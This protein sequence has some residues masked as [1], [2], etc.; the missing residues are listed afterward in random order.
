M[1]RLSTTDLEMSIKSIGAPAVE[2]Q[3]PHAATVCLLWRPSAPRSMR[4]ALID[5]SETHEVR[6]RRVVP[7]AELK[8]GFET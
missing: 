8:A 6:R 4:P 2:R 3:A 5:D 1:R 7:A